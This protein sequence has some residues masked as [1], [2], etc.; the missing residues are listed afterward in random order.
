MAFLVIVLG[1]YMTWLADIIAGAIWSKRNPAQ[2]AQ[3]VD[4]EVRP[5]TMVNT[6]RRRMSWHGIPPCGAGAGG[7]WGR[8]SH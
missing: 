3:I 4:V 2:Q 6:P 8:R 5:L 7:M 1:F